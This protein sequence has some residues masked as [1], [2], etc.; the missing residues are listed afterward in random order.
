[1]ALSALRRA[2]DAM[3]AACA[4]VSVLS[5]VGLAVLILADVAT[6]NLGIGFAWALEGSEYLMMI[7]GF[8]GA[9]WVLRRG[10]HVAIDVVVQMLGAS[11]QAR[12]AR[13]SDAMGLV[14]CAPLTLIAADALF[15][16]RASG[17]LVFKTLIFPEWWLMIPVTA[18]FA[19]MTLEFAL[20]AATG[21]K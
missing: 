1:M 14:I 17:A 19:L 8:V 16:A 10:G 6:R 20:R 12:L 13:A 7:G 21:A 2:Q 9:P 11:R 4:A 3:I 15:K 5:F 18:C